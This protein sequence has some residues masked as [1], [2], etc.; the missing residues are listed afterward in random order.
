M[1]HNK[2]DKSKDDTEPTS[3]NAEMEEQQAALQ[4]LEQEK[5]E[6]VGKL[7]RVSADYA[8]FQRRVPKQ[9][10][11]SIMYEK[12]RILKSILPVLDNF[13]HTLQNAKSAQDFDA[14][15]KGVRIVYDQ[16][17]YIL[18]SHGVEQ[19]ASVGEKFDPTKHEAML[20]KSENDAEDDIVLEEFQKGYRLNERVLRPS[21]VIVNKLAS[22]SDS[23]D[24]MKSQEQSD[25][26]G[27]AAERYEEPEMEE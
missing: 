27:E 4:A 24:A 21:K 22:E 1:K 23:R 17:L 25:N 11:D 15:V 3:L 2:K 18:K 16:M 19:V 7:Q 26:E 6:L 13:E 20:Q 9:V 8:N 14:L 12:E 10:T 5:E